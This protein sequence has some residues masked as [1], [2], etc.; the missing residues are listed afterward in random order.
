MKQFYILN[1]KFLFEFI[2]IILA[3]NPVY[4]KNKKTWYYFNKESNFT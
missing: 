4:G 3:Y 1:I 2:I